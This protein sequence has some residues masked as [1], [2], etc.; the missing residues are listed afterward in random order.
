MK[1]SRPCFHSSEETPHP[2]MPEDKT[3]EVH[4]FRK[5]DDRDQRV[6]VTHRE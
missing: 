6:A 2:T 5:N 3:N 4:V 1:V